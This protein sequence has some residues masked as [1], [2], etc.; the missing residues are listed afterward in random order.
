M[1]TTEIKSEVVSLL[2]ALLTPQAGYAYFRTRPNN[3]MHDPENRRSDLPAIAVYFEEGEPDEDYFDSDTWRSSLHVELFAAQD[4]DVDDALEANAKIII[5]ALMASQL[6]S[7]SELI[8][9]PKFNYNRDPETAITA[10]DLTFTI[11]WEE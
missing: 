10:L 3:L 4:N 7:V 9:S 1:K 5:D 11:Q 2:S 6:P 8:K